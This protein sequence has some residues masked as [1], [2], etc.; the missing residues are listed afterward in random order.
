MCLKGG[1]VQKDGYEAG[2]RE[3]ERDGPGS[4]RSQKGRE[5]DESEKNS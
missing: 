4:P 1:P 5:Y 2:E 3:S